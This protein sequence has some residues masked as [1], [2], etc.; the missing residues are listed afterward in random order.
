MLVPS[1]DGRRI[2][3]VSDA[4]SPSSFPPFEIDPLRPFE[5]IVSLF[6]CQISLVLSFGGFG[7][8]MYFFLINLEFVN[9]FVFLLSSPILEGVSVKYF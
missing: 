8:L 1:F 3:G 6:I 4:N 5:D 2:S 9:I 7:D